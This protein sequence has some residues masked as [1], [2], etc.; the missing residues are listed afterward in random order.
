VNHT[1]GS[2]RK[3]VGGDVVHQAA[4]SAFVSAVGFML[5]AGGIERAGISVFRPIAKRLFPR[6][7]RSISAATFP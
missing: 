2:N 5:Q 6:R 1:I 4:L 3:P 7:G